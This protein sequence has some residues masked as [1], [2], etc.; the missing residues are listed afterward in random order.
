[1]NAI[2]RVLAL[3]AGAILLALGVMFSL[4]LVA[5]I[6]VVALAFGAWAF[7]KTRHLRKA[8][9]EAQAMRRPAPDGDIIE[10]EAVVVDAAVVEGV[11]VDEHQAGERPA[12][13]DE[14]RRPPP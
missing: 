6:A 3:I 2:G 10:G 14:A 12:L 13:P 7:W 9:R 11:I 1:M 4:V 8:L 5:G